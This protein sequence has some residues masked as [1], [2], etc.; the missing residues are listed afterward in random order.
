MPP[1]ET[2]SLRPVTR[3][4][5]RTICDLELADSQR[6]LV[7]PS[8]YT[9]AEGNYEPGA[10]L[11]A[12]YRGDRPVGV[13]LVKLETGTPYLV[14]F[15]VDAQHPR[16][17]VGRRAVELLVDEL[18]AAGWSVLETSHARGADGP[19][20]SGAIAASSRP[21]ASSTTSRCSCV[22]SKR[23]GAARAARS[24]RSRR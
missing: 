20:D 24:A 15:M 16:A 4:N 21:G 5:V 2:V 22:R 3:A 13:L 18:R 23:S 10:G 8:A 11:R 1:D 6:R 7:A 12:I 19:G 17:G 14:R 9:V